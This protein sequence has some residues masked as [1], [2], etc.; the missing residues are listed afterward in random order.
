MSK[1]TKW[2]YFSQKH[3]LIGRLI[4]KLMRW[5]FSCDIS[6]NANIG[7]NCNFE[8]NALGVVISSMATIGDNCK[9]YHGVTVGAGEGGYPTIGNNVVIFTNATIIGGITIG[10]NCVIGANSLVNTSVPENSIVGG[11]PA[12]VLKENNK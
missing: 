1:A 12:R 11:V 5:F 2:F 6:P 10:D 7:K 4:S 8:H 3:K 9:I